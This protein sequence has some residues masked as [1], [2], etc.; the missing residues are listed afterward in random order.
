MPKSIE[1]T[2]WLY[3]QQYNALAERLRAVGVES[4]NKEAERLILE[5]YQQLVPKEEQNKIENE[6]RE[7]IAAEEKQHEESRR[8]GLIKFIENGSVCCF[9]SD[10]LSDLRQ[11]AIVMRRYLRDEIEPVPESLA[12]YYALNGQQEI[13]RDDYDS[14]VQEFGI[15]PNV[16]GVFVFDLDTGIVSTIDRESGECDSYNIK[17][18]STAIY[19][20]QRKTSLAFWARDDYFYSQ[21]DGKELPSEQETEQDDSPAI[22]M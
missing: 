3:E 6:L 9:T 10:L 21:L 19:H 4:V 2:A 7:K 14:Y 5:R 11:N 1:I 16:T 18:V 8:F 22:L 17:D 20:A 12:D 15:H 13:T